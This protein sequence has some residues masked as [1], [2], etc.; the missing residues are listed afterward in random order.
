M[1]ECFR[2]R[3][4][5]EQSNEILHGDFVATV[6]NLDVIAVE[7]QMTPRF[8]VYAPGEFVARVTRDVIS[9]HEDDIRVGDAETLDSAI[10]KNEGL[11]H[12]GIRQ[13]R[14]HYIPR[15][16]AMC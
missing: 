11:Y 4:T 6:V 7:V 13:Q 1:R 5:C 9:E 8:R 16:F 10:P 12:D 15:A 14:Q 2:P 3:H